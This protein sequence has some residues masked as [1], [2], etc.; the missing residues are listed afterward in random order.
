MILPEHLSIPRSRSYLPVPVVLSGQ[1]EWEAGQILREVS[2]PV[3]KYLFGALRDV[4]LWLL[5]PPARRK[6]AFVPG[7]LEVRLAQLGRSGAS[8]TLAQH[9]TNL[10]RICYNDASQEEVGSWCLGVAEWAR[11]EGALRTELEFRQ[12]AALSRPDEPV[13][14]LSVARLAR[15]LSQ[16]QRAET[17][18][19]RSI[20][21]SRSQKNWTPYIRAYLGLGAMYGRLGNGPAARAVTERALRAAR[22]WRLRQLAGEAHHDLFHILVDAGDL[23]HAYDHAESA[24]INYRGASVNLLARLAGDIATLWV[25]IG[26]SQRA[27]P[28][29]QSVIPLTD[30][31]SLR[32]MWSAQLV[33]STAFSDSVSEYD[34]VRAEALK[35]IEQATDLWRRADANLIIAWADLAM[36]AWDE[37]ANM[38]QT[39]F[40]LATSIGATEFIAYADQ[41]I[42]DARAH[43]R[44]GSLFDSVEPPALSRV[45]DKVAGSIL[46]A[47]ERTRARRQAADAS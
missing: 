18:F 41:A 26:A 36:C 15:D 11:A 25:K 40:E 16:H 44:E 28:I 42:R 29:L 12:A 39:A 20:K 13:L 6:V 30:D 5:L 47:V 21:I 17:W 27:R 38:A 24:E 32:A 19:R 1:G 31:P 8:A 35:D 9:L 3:G 33:R 4:M 7:A 34:R 46:V 43:R 2:T 45:A 23:R 10:L 22:R 37:A 14:S